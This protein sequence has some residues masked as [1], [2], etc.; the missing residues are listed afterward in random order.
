MFLKNILFFKFS[1]M[2]KAILWD[3]DGILV[4]TE[5][6]YYEA[7]RLVMQQEGFNLTLDIYRE[8]FLKQN[9]GAWHFLN[10]SDP[11]FI[12]QLR[13]KRNNLYSSFLK[14]K[15][16]Y[17]KDLS[18][19]L[20]IL[21]NKYTM[22]IVTSSRK[23]HFDII[24]QRSNILEYFDFIITSDDFN[25][26]K[27]YP[28]PYLIGIKYSGYRSSECIAIEDSERG[29]EAAKRANLFCIAIPNSMTSNGNFNKAD[30]ILKNID[31]VLIFLQGQLK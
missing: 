4:Q 25:N 3:N 17:T 19:L 21:K 24:H 1:Y 28:D 27:P 10:S 31:E 30:I 8:T 7:T 14:T 18:S 13:E 15:D 16:I 6:W 12:K 20:S 29:V 2:Y 22:G 11:K 9:S 23:D 26:S 5:Q